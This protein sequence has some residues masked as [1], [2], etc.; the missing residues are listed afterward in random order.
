MARTLAG[1]KVV[2]FRLMRDG[3]HWG[4]ERLRS[5][6]SVLRSRAFLFRLRAW[7]LLLPALALTG[8]GAMS[9][10]KNTFLGPPG[11]QTGQLGAVSGFL[12]GVVAD[13]PRAALAARD[14]LSAGGTAAD[15]AVAL[16]F[17]L[18]VTL[19]SRAGLGAGGACMAYAPDKNSVNQGVPEAI[20]FSSVPASGGPKADRPAAVPM[21]ARGMYALAARYGKLQFESLISPA[22]LAARFGVPASR[23][24]VQD[25]S[26]VAGPLMADP[27]S[28]AVF[29]PNGQPLTEG[30]RLIQ[31]E[32]AATLSQL[33]VGG[34][35]DLYQGTLARRL[36]QQSPLAGGPVTLADL[37]TALPKNVPA[38]TLDSGHDKV[39]FL[40]PPAD[41][42]LAAAAAY[43]VLQHN[44]AALEAAN[45]RALAVASQWRAAGGDP[46]ALLHAD[47][48]TATLPALPA[49]T[50]FATL[51]R[52]GNAVVC[53]VSMN[54][55]FGTGRTVPGMGF[56]LAASPAALPLPLLSA[57]IAWN[58]NTH[59]FRAEVGG[60]G[61]EGA[62][63]AVAAG[64][65]YTLRSGR[66]MPVPV[67]EPG[68]ANVIACSGYLPNQSSTCGWAT[69]PRGAGI[70]VGG[71]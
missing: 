31:P 54:N 24:F 58:E 34:V 62:P 67:P 49:S 18:S 2:R 27:V 16:A 66:P 41:G 32:L 8:C 45:A 6:L 48:S 33:R 19:P 50:T 5:V 26:V 39:S 4:F 14:I 29:A 1:L 35:G 61:Q 11:P 46:M 55:L 23:A 60:S 53:A 56:L 52:D 28:A 20:L 44:P 65:D 25:L 64:L 59:A 13:E 63:L 36:D 21:L 70:A 10:V 30:Q 37:R 22:E 69:D 42:G 3:L 57:V 68:R 43:V 12:G 51:D 15:A 38:I 40:P 7:T 71:N 47:V 9:S 17:M